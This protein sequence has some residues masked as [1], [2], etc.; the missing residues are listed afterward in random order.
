VAHGVIAQNLYPFEYVV[1]DPIPQMPP[2]A[3]TGAYIPYVQLI[4]T[5]LDSNS[6]PI[7][8]QVKNAVYNEL[9]AVAVSISIDQ[10][11]P[12]LIT[13]ANG[14][15]CYYNDGT[16][17]NAEGHS[18]AIVGWDDNYPKTNFGI[19][20]PG[21]GAYLIKNSWGPGWGNSGYFWM[22][23]YETSLEADAYVFNA[24]SPSSPYNWVYQYD[25]LGWLENWGFNS[26]TSSMANVFKASPQ[27]R[28]IRAVSF[29]TVS[30]GTK[31][32]VKIYDKCPTTSN[33]YPDSPN[34]VVD[35]VGGK[36]LITDSGTCKTAGYNTHNLSKPVTV[37]YGT[38][39]P[40]NFSV[41]LAVNDTTG[42]KSPLAVQAPSPNF[43]PI[44]GQGYMSPSGKEGTWI[45]IVSLNGMAW[46]GR[47]CIKAFATA[48]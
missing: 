34:A 29:W 23:Y 27:G 14:D 47:V 43:N 9:N 30:P 16:S 22:S 5:G 2:S 41:V 17:Q 38:T 37:S 20:P 32:T 21:N 24:A 42:Y 15:T 18:I 13:A 4:T 8:D 46:A 45:D 35:P 3:W 36:L 12:Y 40:V 48:N 33:N 10:S 44:M 25:P 6:N 31:Y 28:V 26:T 19:T 11:S 1:R 39:S 7:T